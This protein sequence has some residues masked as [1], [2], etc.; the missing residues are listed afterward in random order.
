M[1]L[2][3]RPDQQKQHHHVTERQVLRVY[4]HHLVVVVWHAR[5]LQPQ[6]QQFPSEMGLV[7]KTDGFHFHQIVCLMR[8]PYDISHHLSHQLLL[9]LLDC[10][11]IQM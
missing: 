11:K 3:Q 10:P 7:P 8:R 9:D 2:R 1:F 6:G 5:A 4:L